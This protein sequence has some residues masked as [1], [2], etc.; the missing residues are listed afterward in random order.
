MKPKILVFTDFYLPGY[1]SGGMRAIVNMVDRL[2]DEFDFYIVTRNYDGR[3]N[4]EIY[5]TVKT[6]AWNKVGRANVFYISRNDITPWKIKK[7]IEEVSPSAIYSNSY[8]STFTIFITSLRKLKLIKRIPLIIAPEGELVEG[9]LRLKK[10]KKSIYIS[11]AKLLRLYDNVIWKVTSEFEKRETLPFVGENHVIMVAPNIPPKEVLSEFDID[12]KPRKERGEAEIVFLSRIH[13]TKNLV[14]LIETLKEQEAKVSLDVY[15]PVDDSE[16]FQ[17][18]MKTIEGLNKISFKGEV[19]HEDVPK[20]LMR[21]HFFAL[22]TLGENFGHVVIEALAAG[23]PLIISDKTPWRKLEKQGIG[24]DLPLD[25]ERWKE[26]LNEC[27]RMDDARYREMS[28]KARA[29]AE[30]WLRDEEVE[31]ATRR[32]ILKALEVT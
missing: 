24:W 18:C 14:F 1:K 13:P 28:S 4:G 20:T 15:G 26:T 19:R 2:G 30:N 25:K 31:D 9:A 11:I 27:I 8:F 10:T 3:V 12:K 16:Y 21:Y 29:F 23:C 7:L 17:K 32:V 5:D 6:G 22:P